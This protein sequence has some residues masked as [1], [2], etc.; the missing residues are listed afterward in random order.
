[1]QKF[2]VS[3]KSFYKS[4]YGFLF[5]VFFFKCYLSEHASQGFV[6]FQHRNVLPVFVSYCSYS[7]RHL[8]GM[9]FDFGMIRFF[10]FLKKTKLFNGTEKL[11]SVSKY[12]LSNL[13]TYRL[14]MKSVLTTQGTSMIV[15]QVWG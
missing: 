7:T 15:S 9:F 6:D 12:I 14:G 4:K 8:R 10:F 2:E 5:F 13:S 1:M 11:I 3:E